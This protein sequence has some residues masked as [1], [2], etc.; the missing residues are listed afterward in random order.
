MTNERTTMRDQ[1]VP[2]PAAC[3]FT[4]IRCAVEHVGGPPSLPPGWVTVAGPA[5]CPDCAPR[6]TDDQDQADG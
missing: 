6:A 2:T 4:C 5:L 1:R 3:I